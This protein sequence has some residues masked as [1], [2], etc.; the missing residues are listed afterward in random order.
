PYYERAVEVDPNFAMAYTALAVSYSNLGQ[1]TQAS[2]NSQKAFDLRARVSERERYRIGARYYTDVTGE[3]DKARQ[4]Y[5]LWR[6]S[7]PRDPL[8]SESLGDIYR[9]RGRWEKALRETEDTG[10]L[11]PNSAMFNSN[12]A[13]A[14]LA[15]NRREEA[16]STLEKALARKLDSQ[17]IRL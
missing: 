14:Q 3:L 15:L 1:A 5:E 17:F 16:R 7:Y 10:R 12:Q 4:T 8:P 6:Q 11:D 9:R 2:E 13:W